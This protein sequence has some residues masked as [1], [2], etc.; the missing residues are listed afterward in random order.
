[1]KH[2]ALRQTASFSHKLSDDCSDAGRI[3]PRK[4]QMKALIVM[5]VEI[6]RAVDF[7]F[8]VMRAWLEVS[9]DCCYTLCEL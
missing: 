6:K 2:C 5:F 4:L 3:L 9:C 1:M 8:L 7:E